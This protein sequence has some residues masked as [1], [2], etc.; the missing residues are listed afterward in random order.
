MVL[1][2]AIVG[3][4]WAGSRQIEGITELN[5][6]RAEGR[7]EIEIAMLVDSDAEH[8]SRTAERFGVRRTATRLEAALEDRE[9]DAISIASPHEFHCDQAVKAAQAGKHALVEK[10]MAV[11]VDEATTTIEAADAAEVKLF[12]AESE[13][14]T[15]FS[16]TLY[17][18]A[19][20]PP[21]PPL[22]ELTFVTA[23]HGFRAQPRYRYEGRRAWLADPKLGG[24]GTW[25]LHGIHTVA[26]IQNALGDVD[27]VYMREFHTDSFAI[28][29]VEG[30]MVGLLTM[31]SGLPVA[32]VQ[33]CDT[34]LGVSERGCVFHGTHGTV[35]VGRDDVEMLS[36]ANEPSTAGH[37][38]AI[39]DADTPS[40]YALEWRAFADY[41]SRDVEG[42]T[43]GRRE[44]RP[45]AVVQAGHES[46]ASGLPVS[47]RERFGD[48]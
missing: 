37:Y 17:R 45:L 16:R 13:V 48:L 27:T 3:V 30:P 10:P 15:R 41:V 1:R 14:Y 5:E 9:I 7:P 18:I 47:I 36:T 25:T 35:R 29:N 42:P 24:T 31:A 44:R 46:A 26:Q 8:L 32:L 21:G 20:T 19:R 43:S 23:I 12:V 38:A 2:V 4:G 33:T 40:E 11:D 6:S 34:E 39:A 28:P 22:G